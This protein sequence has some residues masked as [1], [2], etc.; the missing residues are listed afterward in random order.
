MDVEML[1]SRLRDDD[2]SIWAY[3]DQDTLSFGMHTVQDGDEPA[4]ATA[5]R[6]ALK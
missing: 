4:I 6:R 2:P 3:A 1:A 5:L